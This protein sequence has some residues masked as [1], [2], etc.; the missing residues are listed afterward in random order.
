VT[1]AYGFSDS[2]AGQDPWQIHA[3]TPSGTSTPAGTTL[4]HFGQVDEGVFKGSKPRT[5]ADFA[6]LQAH[7]ITY[8]LDLELLPSFGHSEAKRA[9]SHGIVILHRRINASPISPSE[10]HIEAIMAV[11]KN[12][13]YRPIYFHCAY[14]RDRTSLIAALYKMYYLAMSPPDALRDMEESG[15]KDSWVRNGL[16]RYLETHPNRRAALRE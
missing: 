15:Y 13:R 4:V 2:P 1:L 5:G 9:K 16:K 10:K 11:L 14:G 3:A 7:H 8:I 12:S 6:F